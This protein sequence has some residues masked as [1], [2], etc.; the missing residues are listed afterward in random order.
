MSTP[1][2]P[3]PALLGVTIQL[4]SRHCGLS[5]SAISIPENCVLLGILRQGQIILASE[6]PFISVGDVILAIALQRMFIPA[7]KVA[8]GRSHSVYYSLHDCLLNRSAVQ[9]CC[10]VT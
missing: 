5:L 1:A 8:L 3:K 2:L 4:N 6:D 9:T 7:L 10:R